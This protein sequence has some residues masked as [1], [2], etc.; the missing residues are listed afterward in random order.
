MTPTLGH[1][2]LSL[3]IDLL[4]KAWVLYVVTEILR[5]VA[6]RDPQPLLVTGCN[7]LKSNQARCARVGKD[8]QV[9]RGKVSV[10]IVRGCLEISLL[11]PINRSNRCKRMMSS[12]LRAR[13]VDKRLL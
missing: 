12:Y 1:A 11:M 6:V 8:V 5:V 10:G 9:W 2:W 3:Y 4:P 13:V 7:W